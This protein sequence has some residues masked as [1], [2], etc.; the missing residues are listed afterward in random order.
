M[1]YKEIKGLILNNITKQVTNNIDRI[2]PQIKYNA[3]FIE[4]HQLKLRILASEVWGVEKRSNYDSFTPVAAFIRSSSISNFFSAHLISVPRCLKTS[5]KRYL[6]SSHLP[7]LH[8]INMLM[9]S[10]KKEKILS[11][12]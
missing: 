9:R 8:L 7:T 3:L 6:L 10:G 4:P 5:S 1:D 12:V 11:V 2:L